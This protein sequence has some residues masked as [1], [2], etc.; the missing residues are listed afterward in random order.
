MVICKCVYSKK[1]RLGSQFVKVVTNV[2]LETRVRISC[3]VL[4][5]T[6]LAPQVTAYIS[7]NFETLKRDFH[8]DIAN[9]TYHLIVDEAGTCQQ[10]LETWKLA[11][12]NVSFSST[13]INN[14]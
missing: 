4:S 13:L 8:F 14:T 6:M 10:N 3:I 7:F 9:I 2:W 11:Q 12:A 1:K 5:E